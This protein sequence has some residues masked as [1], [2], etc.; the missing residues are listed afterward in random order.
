MTDTAEVVRRVQIAAVRARSN[1]AEH[2][3]LDVCE[4]LDPLCYGDG[5][6]DVIGVCERVLADGREPSAQDVLNV[7]TLAHRSPTMWTAY[8]VRWREDLPDPL[9]TFRRL[10]A[11]GARAF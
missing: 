7:L 3:M 9:D 5:L 4:M 10:L 11:E 2:D 8:G 6:T 1:A